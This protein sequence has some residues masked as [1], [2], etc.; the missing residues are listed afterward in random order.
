MGMKRIVLAVAVAL[1]MAAVYAAPV[2]AG[3]VGGSTTWD[4]NGSENLPCEDGG[5]WILSP[6]QGITAATL[7]VNGVTYPM[8]QSGN[9]GSYSAD[10]VGALDENT[11]ASATW[12]GEN[13]SAFLKLSHCIEAAETTT[14][15]GTGG[16]GAGGGGGGAGAGGGGGSGELPF[17]G[18]PILVPLLLGAALLGSGILLLRRGRQ[19]N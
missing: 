18:L 2:L 15:G 12:T 6:A 13:D 9:N 10:S 7:T 17:T 8:T 11:T 3:G 4:G 5:H 16:A 1:T 14:G 19:Q